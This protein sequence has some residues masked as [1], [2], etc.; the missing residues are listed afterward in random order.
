MP[1]VFLLLQKVHAKVHDSDMKL[2][3]SEPKIF[4][5]GV[6]IKSWSK[7][8][9]KDKKEALSKSW[10]VYYSYKDPKTGKLKRQ[11][12]IIRSKIITSVPKER[13]FPSR[14]CLK[15]TEQQP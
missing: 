3:Y 7:L 2:D 15:I 9:K 4:T 6:D 14:K 10:Y 11:T 1:S 8:S 13:S 12:N 5:G